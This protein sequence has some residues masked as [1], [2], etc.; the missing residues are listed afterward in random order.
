MPYRLQT[1][2]LP[3]SFALQFSVLLVSSGLI[4]LACPILFLPKLYGQACSPEHL[5]QLFPILVLPRISGSCCLCPAML[6]F[7]CHPLLAEYLLL[8]SIASEI[9]SE[10]FKSLLIVHSVQ[11]ELV[12]LCCFPVSLCYFSYFLSDCCED[13]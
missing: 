1:A 6:C 10:K 8:R 2:P 9:S 5:P 13:N 11:S 3:V 12:F 7:T 4:L